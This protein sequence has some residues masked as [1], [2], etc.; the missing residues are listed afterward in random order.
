MKVRSGSN[1]TIQIRD[2]LVDTISAYENNEKL[3]EELN[4]KQQDL[5][6]RLE[7]SNFNASEGF[8][9]ARELKD[10]R[11]E[12]RRCYNENEVLKPLYDYLSGK[13]KMKE[14]LDKI[15]GECRQAE[16]RIESKKYTPRY[17]DNDF[18]E[19][20]NLSKKFKE[21]IEWV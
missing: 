20:N 17:S 14:Q 18:D 5:L 19:L 16:R 1:L 7:W 21:E 13:G 10:I 12:R 3:I 9:L 11:V 4:A 8:K 15:V 2:A 6:H